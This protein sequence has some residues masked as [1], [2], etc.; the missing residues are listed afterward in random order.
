MLSDNVLLFFGKEI[1]FDVSVYD[2]DM[3]SLVLG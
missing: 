1:L 2:F 3:V